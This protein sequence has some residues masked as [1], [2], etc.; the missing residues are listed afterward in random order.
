MLASDRSWITNP[1]VTPKKDSRDGFDT[2]DDSPRLGALGNFGQA[3]LSTRGQLGVGM[4][5]YKMMS[6]VTCCS[7]RF[8]ISARTSIWWISGLSE[9]CMF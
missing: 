9:H 8:F 3:L 4:D 5:G 7:R 2:D 1:W 6:P